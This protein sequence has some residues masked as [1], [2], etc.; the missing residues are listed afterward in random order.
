MG[1]ENEFTKEV[2]IFVTSESGKKIEIDGLKFYD[3]SPNVPAQEL[4]GELVKDTYLTDIHSIERTRWDDEINKEGEAV[5][6]KHMDGS[7]SI[8]T[9]VVSEEKFYEVVNSIMSQRKERKDGMI[10]IDMSDWRDK[11][12]KGRLRDERVGEDR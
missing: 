7:N 1:M 3:R 11:K 2:H 6:V 8:K 4:T 5:E 12:I 9:Y 10:K